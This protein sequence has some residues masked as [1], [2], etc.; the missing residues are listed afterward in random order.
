MLAFRLLHQ[1]MAFASNKRD[2]MALLLQKTSE[3][4]QKLLHPSLF[5]KGYSQD[6]PTLCVRHGSRIGWKEEDRQN[7]C[8]ALQDI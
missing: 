6:K 5:S 7:I 3:A 1:P 2:V 4:Q 8:V